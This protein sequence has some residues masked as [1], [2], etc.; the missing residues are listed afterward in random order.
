MTA[1]G[2]P[3]GYFCLYKIH[4]STWG[5][6]NSRVT[7]EG[8]NEA[9]RQAGWE[10]DSTRWPPQNSAGALPARFALFTLKALS[11]IELKR[12]KRDVALDSLLPLSIADSA[13]RSDGRS[14]MI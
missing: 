14:F 9:A 1:P 8:M 11:F 4:T 5:A 3:A 7:I 10:L 6:S 13:A 2:E 12:G